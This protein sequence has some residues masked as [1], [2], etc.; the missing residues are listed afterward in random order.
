M[1]YLVTGGAG[2]IGSHYLNYVYNDKDQYV[3]IDCLSYASNLDN[4]K[5]LMD[6][7]NFKFIKENICNEDEIF[8]IFKEEKF[9]YVIHFAAETHV[10]NSIDNYDLFYRSNVVGTKVLLDASVK[11]G[12]K[13]FHHISTDEVYG[14]LELDS[15]YVFTEESKLNPTNNYSKTKALAESLVFDYYNKYDLDITITRSSNNYGLNQYR[16]KLIPKIIYNALNNIIIPIYGDG[17]NKRDWLYVLDNCSA[18]D[19]VV[20]KGIKGEVYNICSNEELANNEVVRLILKEM[21][22]DESLIRYVKDRPNH[23][24]KY[25][26]DCSKIMSLGWSPKY[27]FKEGIKSII[28]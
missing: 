19:L 4:I 10:D 23:D 27:K 5:N 6:K 9:D 8:N 13:R 3:C 14:S 11:Y 24:K 21:N 7:P 16:E 12:V 20:H 28:K 18:I 25:T 22:K 26:M 15:S 2:F 17:T 1:K